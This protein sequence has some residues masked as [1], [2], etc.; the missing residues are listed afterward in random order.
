MTA[1]VE[2]GR[3]ST[4]WTPTTDP[5]IRPARADDPGGVEVTADGLFC[6]EDDIA[7]AALIRSTAGISFLQMLGNGLDAIVLMLAGSTDAETAQSGAATASV[8]NAAARETD[9]VNQRL[10]ALES[11]R[12]SMEEAN[13][14]FG[15]FP[16]PKWVQKIITAIIMSIALLAAAFTG[17][18]SLA[19][20]VAAVALMIVAESMQLAMDEGIIPNN[21]LTQG[22][23]IGVQAAAAIC[24]LVG[25]NVG[26]VANTAS[27]VALT[28]GKAVEIS[29]QV[30]SVADFVRTSIQSSFQIA[31]A[32]FK[33]DSE[34]FAA[35]AEEWESLLTST[36]EALSSGRADVQAIM[37]S[38]MDMVE[39]YFDLSE[40]NNS[41][42]LNA[43]IS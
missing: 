30:L 5:L 7:I 4:M 23:M 26:G 38:L 36:R 15:L 14:F 21:E 24:S 33:R 22:L 40:T 34:N 9:Q 28:V 20:T 29:Q 3:A 41:A 31:G 6:P 8:E 35:D 12:A 19:L 11:A 1:V 42:R 18:A 32:V 13:K 37:E 2:T 43:V 27:T 39:A 25:G 17:G 10:D 16:M